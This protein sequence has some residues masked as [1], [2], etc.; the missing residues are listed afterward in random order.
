MNVRCL[1]SRVHDRVA[2]GGV[3][4]ST[5]LGVVVVFPLG[6]PFCDGNSAAKESFKLSRGNVEE[7]IISSC[8]RTLRRVGPSTSSNSSPH[9]VGVGERCI[10]SSSVGL[11]SPWVSDGED[12]LDSVVSFGDVAD[13]DESVGVPR[14]Q[15]DAICVVDGNSGEESL[16]GDGLEKRDKCSVTQRGGC[17]LF[18]RSSSQECVGFSHPP[19]VS[20]VFV[21]TACLSVAFFQE[22]CP[23][24]S[25]LSWP[26]KYWVA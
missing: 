26:G 4:G 14:N 23:E 10:E 15:V 12:T 21:V 7:T 1:G 25:V 18:V 5:L 19:S 2:V 3:V 9:W 13:R 22:D 16:R 24:S 17:V 8:L 6:V 11:R 20:D